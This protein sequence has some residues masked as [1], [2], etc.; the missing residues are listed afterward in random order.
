MIIRFLILLSLLFM[1]LQAQESI[2]AEDAITIGLK[3]NYNIRIARN[4]ARIARNNAGKGTAGF[5]PTIDASGFSQLA[6]SDQE[7]N[8]PFS[9]GGG[10]SDTETLNGRIALNWTIFDGLKM[11]ASKAQFNALAELGEAQ[12]RNTIENTVVTV[13]TAYFNLVQQEQRLDVARNSRDISAERLEKATIRREVGGASS[14]DLL[15]ARVA[16]NNDQAAVLEQELAVVIARNQ[17]NIALAQD[18]ATS[19]AVAEDILVAPMDIAIEELQRLAA[20]NNSGLLVARHNKTSAD[21]GVEIARG[22]FLPRVTLS[23]DYGYTD[24]NTTVSTMRENFPPEI[25]TQSTDGTISLNASLNLFNGFRDKIDLQNARITARNQQLQ[26]EKTRMEL[27]GIVAEKN[28][29]FQNRL[30][31]LN[32]ELEN[33]EA[34]RQ[35]LALIQD[36]YRIGAANSLE[37]RDAQ[38]NLNRAEIALITARYQARI[39]RLEIERLIG[40]LAIQ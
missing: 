16:F 11:F 12:A 7:T 18:P 21:K 24:R 34:A 10:I 20:D 2:S 8:N 3:N 22:N 28:A 30:Q 36:R 39:S 15:N 1:P 9:A 14:T 29:E 37:F 17:L 25:S 5:L 33:V 19:F 23:A 35:N 13:L 27:R 38:V 6:R 26:L 32:L 4:D 31:L 40:R